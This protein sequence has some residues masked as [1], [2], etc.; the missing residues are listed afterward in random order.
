MIEQN[1][2]FSRSD[3]AAFLAVLLSIAA[4]GIGIVEAKIM[5]DQQLIMAQQQEVMVEQQKGSA[6]PY[7]EVKTS[8]DIIG[9]TTI[10][11]SA[12][13]K[14]VGPAIITNANIMLGDK[15]FNDGIEFSKALESILGNSDFELLDFST[16]PNNKIVFKPGE[17]KNFLK[18]VL[19]NPLDFR[20]IGSPFLTL[21]YCSIYNDCWR[22]NGSEIKETDQPN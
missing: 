13:N 16:N 10:I 1:K 19:L 4:L 11:C 6:W 9:Q 3:M 8:M 21:N 2:K 22:E 18:L 14:G 5:A 20:K 15:V 17:K 12:E 7:V